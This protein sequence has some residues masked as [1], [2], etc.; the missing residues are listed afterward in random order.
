MCLW[1]QH[2]GSLR[3]R[4][5]VLRCLRCRRLSTPPGRMQAIHRDMYRVC[6]MSLSSVYFISIYLFL[7]VCYIIHTNTHTYIHAHVHTERHSETHGHT[8]THTNHRL[9]THILRPCILKRF[10]CSVHHRCRPTELSDHHRRN[11]RVTW[12]CDLLLHGHVTWVQCVE[13]MKFH[14]IILP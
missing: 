9:W 6:Y 8:H 2:V 10:R 3:W 7:E 1:L 4:C 13:Q 11:D 12:S 14:S 5:H